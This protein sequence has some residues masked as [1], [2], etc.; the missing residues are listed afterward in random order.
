M[1]EYSGFMCLIC[2]CGAAHE[3]LTS[4]H[5]DGRQT[6]IRFSEFNG[7]TALSN[8]A[9]VNIHKSCQRRF[10][11]EN[12]APK[13]QPQEESTVGKFLRSQIVAFLWKEECLV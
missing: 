9:V 2:T 8:P 6:I 4:V 12:Y 13:T 3:K 5:F 10:T 1:G 11:N 7:N